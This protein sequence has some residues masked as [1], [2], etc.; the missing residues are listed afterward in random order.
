ML[1]KA[2]LIVFVALLPACAVQQRSNDAASELRGFRSVTVG[3]ASIDKANDLWV[4]VMGF[5]V[6]AERNGAD[7]ELE[8]LWDVDADLIARQVM[9][10]SRDNDFGLLHLVEY[11]QPVPAVRDGAAVFDLVPKNL[12]VYTENLPAIVEKMGAEGY[13]FRNQR[14]SEVTAPDGTMFREIHLPS[15]D[16]VNVVLLEVIGKQLPFTHNGFAGIGPLIYIVPDASAEKAF[17]RDVMRFDKLNDNILDGPEIERMVGLPPGAGLDVSIWGRAGDSFGGLEPI[18]Y[19]GVVGE[20]R[21]PLAVPGARGVLHVSYVVDDATPLLERLRAGGI[22]VDDRGTGSTLI[23]D[24]RMYRFF[25]PA[26]LAFE[27]YERGDR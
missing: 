22:A 15:H 20:N 11:S 7:P 10:R 5:E 24:G 21:Y 4:D 19:Q 16:D 2:W 13:R 6:V 8:R 3:V 14:Y 1:Q 17:L 27:L 12:D 26:G 23:A 18:E 25:S 9:L